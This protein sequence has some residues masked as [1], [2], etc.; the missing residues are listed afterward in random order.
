MVK[1]Q[2]N[3]NMYLIMAKWIFFSSQV[4]FNLDGSQNIQSQNEKF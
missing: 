4:L 2:N 3:C 1:G